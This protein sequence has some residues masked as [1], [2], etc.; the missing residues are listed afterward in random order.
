MR[1][2]EKQMEVLDKMYDGGPWWSPT[3]VGVQ[4]IKAAPEATISR[5]TYFLNEL[6]KKEL[7]RKM[8]G[9][10]RLTEKGAKQV[11]DARHLASLK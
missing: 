10:Y 8:E 4:I 1:V 3:D 9:Y 5:A 7:L 6:Y 2:P 11:M